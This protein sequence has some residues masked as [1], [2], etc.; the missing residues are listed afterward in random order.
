MRPLLPALVL[1]SAVL[2]A[3]AGTREPPAAPPAAGTADA[4]PGLTVFT[5]AG[6]RFSVAYPAGWSASQPYEF[7]SFIAISPV[8]AAG[9]GGGSLSVEV[10]SY[11]PSWTAADRAASADSVARA[12]GEDAGPGRSRVASFGPAR[13]GALP[14]FRLVVTGDESLGRGGPWYQTLYVADVP[15]GSGQ[16]AFECGDESHD[17]SLCD[18]LAAT[19][20]LGPP[21]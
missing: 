14:A 18:R 8:L 19:F 12:E 9:E 4:L 1:L 2:T 5:E 13:L 6:G 17:P 7:P 15:D 11:G 21:D 10:E 20:A 16:V 3:C